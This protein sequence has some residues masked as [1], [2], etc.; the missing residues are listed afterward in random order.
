MKTILIAEDEFGLAE[1]L[2][3]LLTDEGYRVVLAR[4]GKQASSGS[5][6]RT[7]TS[8]SSIT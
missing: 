7:R 6:R 8:R 1:G 3:S 5:G 4:D 2:S